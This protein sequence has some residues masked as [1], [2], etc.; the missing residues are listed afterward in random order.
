MCGKATHA[1]T[2]ELE[3]QNATALPPLAGL[4]EL[5]RFGFR[6][7]RLDNL[8]ALAH[9]PKLEALQFSKAEVGNTSALASLKVLRW[10]GWIG[11][12]DETT[13]SRPPPALR[14]LLLSQAELASLEP[15][16]KLGQLETLAF[17]WNGKEVDLAGV[18]K[19]PHLRELDLT[20]TTARNYSTLAGLSQ[21]RAIRITLERQG[22]EALP[23]LTDNAKLDT[24]TLVVRGKD[25]RGASRL[26]QGRKLK[27][28]NVGEAERLDLTP[29]SKLTGLESLAVEQAS[30]D[31]AQAARF[32]KLRELDLTHTN[33]ANLRS[34]TPLPQLERFGVKGATR[35]ELRALSGARNLKRLDLY[36][37]R[38][39]DLT[40]LDT[41]PALES[42]LVETPYPESDGPQLSFGSLAGVAK[43]KKL[44]SLRLRLDPQPE[45]ALDLSPLRG[46]KTLTDLAL[47][48]AER[49]RNTA[50]LTSVPLRELFVYAHTS[51][52]ASVLDAEHLRVLHL[53]YVDPAYL[54]GIAHLSKLEELTV[55]SEDFGQLGFLA[56]LLQLRKLELNGKIQSLERLAALKRLEEL[57]LSL[58]D[59]DL[60]PLRGLKRLRKLTL[61]NVRVSRESLLAFQQA[62]PGCEIQVGSPN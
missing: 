33:A 19:F 28:L 11:P 8:D 36:R 50:A 29:L 2:L 37:A 38:I 15:L 57:T 5:R 43:L 13:F 7:G 60:A 6:G 20:Q 26:A 10:L 24:V 35:R 48:G 25:L 46:A 61:T 49:Y 23:S 51:F 34:L 1:G 58:S 47:M 18:S 44:R 4:V 21:L 31:I 30:I 39:A 62:H 59:L 22:G 3:C 55:G 17:K 56:K 53:F 27:L 42:L 40:A 16:A 9:L 32:K 45:Q 12:V 14:H 41:L 54:A 52:D